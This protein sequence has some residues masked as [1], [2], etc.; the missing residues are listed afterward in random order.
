[1]NLPR[2]GNDPLLSSFTVGSSWMNQVTL[3]TEKN[4]GLQISILVATRIIFE[5]HFAR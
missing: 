4:P 3:P 1:V 2:F 5:G